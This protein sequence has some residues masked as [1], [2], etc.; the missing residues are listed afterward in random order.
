MICSNADFVHLQ[1]VNILH[2]DLLGS[3]SGHYMALVTD[4]IVTDAGSDVK[5]G[6]NTN[7]S[8]IDVSLNSD[9]GNF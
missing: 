2:N 8:S 1:H 5:S 6:H 7:I 9:Q 3:N 4:P